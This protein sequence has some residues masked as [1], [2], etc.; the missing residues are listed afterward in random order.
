MFGYLIA[1]RLAVRESKSAAVTTSMSSLGMVHV[2]A[3]GGGR[4]GKRI[5]FSEF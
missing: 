1:Y 5:Y 2:I 3:L 4:E